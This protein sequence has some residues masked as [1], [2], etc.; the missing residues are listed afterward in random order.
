MAALTM[1]DRQKLLIISSQI[2]YPT[3]GISKNISNVTLAL[4]LWKLSLKM[5]TAGLLIHRQKQR[6]TSKLY[7]H[8]IAIIV[9][10]PKQCLTFLCKF[11]VTISTPLISNVSGN[12]GL[13]SPISF[14]F[15][16]LQ[17]GFCILISPLILKIQK[18]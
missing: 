14:F 1:D 10:Y 8:W 6:V 2:I 5:E 16:I 13:K 11:F 17:Q 3:F 15:N 18:S 9:S 4:K 12:T 7:N